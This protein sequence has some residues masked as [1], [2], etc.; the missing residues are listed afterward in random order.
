ME[1]IDLTSQTSYNIKTISKLQLLGK[2]QTDLQW[3]TV[4]KLSDT[5]TDEVLQSSS[6]FHRFKNSSVIPASE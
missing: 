4:K 6:K 2:V 3:L 1:L 5:P